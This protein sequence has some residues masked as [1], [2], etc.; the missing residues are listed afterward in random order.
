MY[1]VSCNR[2]SVI[3]EQ[4]AYWPAYAV[5]ISQWTNSPLSLSKAAGFNV[6]HVN[7]LSG[8]GLTL[9]EVHAQPSNVLP[10]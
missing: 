10:N 4:N 2:L 1:P 6:S 7:C 5:R 8:V 3:N 9:N